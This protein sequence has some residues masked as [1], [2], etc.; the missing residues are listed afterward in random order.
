MPQ[1]AVLPIVRSRLPTGTSPFFSRLR[2]IEVTARATGS[3][4]VPLLPR[5]AG[6]TDEDRHQL[7]TAF[8]VEQV[9]KVLSLGPAHALAPDRSL[10]D[11]GMDSL[12]AMELRNRIVSAVEVRIAVADLLQGPT[13]SQLA[14]LILQA[15][16]DA[17]RTAQ[18]AEREEMEL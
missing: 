11:M 8:L 9:G 10:L 7:V 4:M 18:P 17:A 16:P 14:A 15:L 6:A 1:V 3:A 12:M 13:T 2:E 5:L